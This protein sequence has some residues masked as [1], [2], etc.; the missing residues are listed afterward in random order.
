MAFTSASISMSFPPAARNLEMKR[1]SCSTNGEMMSTSLGRVLR[2]PTKGAECDECEK[3]EATRACVR[4]S[5]SN[6]HFAAI[7]S[8]MMAPVVSAI[9]LLYMQAACHLQGVENTAL[10]S[11]VTPHL[12]QNDER[13]AVSP[14]VNVVSPEQ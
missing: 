5:A 9:W 2:S 11:G 14:S 8:D 3:G 12:Q 13:S 4:S 1:M 10:V 7:S 6:G